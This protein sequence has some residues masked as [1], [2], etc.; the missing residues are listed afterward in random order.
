MTEG[1]RVISTER[2]DVVHCP[3]GPYFHLTVCYFLLLPR[4]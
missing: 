4:Q 3:V 1:V 2:S